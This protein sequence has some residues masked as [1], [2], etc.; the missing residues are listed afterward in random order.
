MK[1]SIREKILSHR[2]TPLFLMA[3]NIGLFFYFI[4]EHIAE[5]FNMLFAILGGVIT[6][7]ISLWIVE[8]IM[9]KLLDKVPIITGLFCIST[10]FVF[11]YFFIVKTTNFS[12]NQ[13][14]SNGILTNAVV[15]DKTKIYGKKGNSIHSMKVTFET[16][17]NNKK[18]ATIDLTDTEY[19]Y[20]KKGMSI[21][22]YYSSKHPNIATIAYDKLKE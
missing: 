12:V 15:I 13:I 11:G 20:F 1:T 2:L 7:I 21:P 22:I 17:D 3:L 6:L 5:R 8:L 16:K 10:F 19:S 18:E 9:P 4:P 14:A